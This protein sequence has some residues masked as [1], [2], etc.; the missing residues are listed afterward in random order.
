MLDIDASL[1]KNQ[2]LLS[3]CPPAKKAIY[4]LGDP[5]EARRPVDET[6]ISQP[7]PKARCFVN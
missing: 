1:E 6:P 7:R 2:D 4:R 3:N 5:Y